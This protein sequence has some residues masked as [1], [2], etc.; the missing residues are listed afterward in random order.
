MYQS[1]QIARLHISFPKLVTLSSVALFGGLVLGALAG[2]IAGFLW[3]IGVSA[4]LLGLIGG[5]GLMY[6]IHRLRVRSQLATVG[7]ALFATLA[8]YVGLYGVQYV[9]FLN[10][11]RTEIRAE[12]GATDDAIMDIAIDE[13]LV[14]LVGVGGLPGFVALQAHEGIQFGR[15]MSSSSTRMGTTA[16]WVYMAA[17]IAGT[18]IVSAVL[19]V[20]ATRELFCERCQNWLKPP[21]YI[22]DLA[23]DEAEAF[24]AHLKAYRIAEAAACIQIAIPEPGVEVCIQ[25]CDQPELHDSRIRLHIATGRVNGITQYRDIWSGAIDPRMTDALSPAD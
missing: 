4:L 24:V 19:A 17:E 11:A 7:V 9:Q 12:Y 1:A 25:R 14:G 21:H 2:I 6:V 20:S 18:L 15:M 10:N 5:F 22:G 16:S 3:L 23:P 8:M 13:T